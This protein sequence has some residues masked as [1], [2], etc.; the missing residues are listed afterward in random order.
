MKIIG[1]GLAG[2]IAANMIPDSVVLE[3]APARTESHKAV[4]RFKSDSVAKVTGINFKKVM[5]RKAIVDGEDII[6]ECN[7]RLGNR[8]AAKVSGIIDGEHS[9]WNLG[10]GTRYIAPHNFYDLLVDRLE[11]QGRIKFGV[12][13]QPP[14]G[15]RCISTV[16]LNITLAQL[17]V[18]TSKFSTESKPIFV[19]IVALNGVSNIYQTLYFVKE[20]FPVYRAS[21]TDN[22]LIV[23]MMHQPPTMGDCQM[24]IEKVAAKFGLSLDMLGEVTTHHQKLGKILDL[25]P[26]VRRKILYDL[27]RQHGIYSLGRFAT[28]RNIMLDDVVDD[29]NKIQRLL[30]LDDYSLL[31]AI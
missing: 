12:D 10:H 6:N 22:R 14:I 28:W 1:G 21:I 23:E 29:V 11:S 5:V 30:T 9:I 27:T 15:E 18:G 7:I 16:P 3:R 4:L 31:S 25:D 24:V 13:V 19:C 17:G 20:N 26:V 2:L 8:Y